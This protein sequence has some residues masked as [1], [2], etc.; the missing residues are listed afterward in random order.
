M[1]HVE[2]LAER[3]FFLE[4]DVQ[5]VPSGPVETNTELQI[6]L[7]KAAE[8]EQARAASYNQAAIKCGQNA[9]A[10]S[11]QVFEALVNDEERHFDQFDKQLENI[12]RFGPN[13][14]AL[15]SFDKTPQQPAATGE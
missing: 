8:M 5:I 10:A 15:Q 13:Y 12:K 2:R 9:D 4:G 14:L 11:K 6:I 3:I 1:G 7:A